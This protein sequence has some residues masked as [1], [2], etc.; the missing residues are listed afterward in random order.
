[1]KRRLVLVLALALCASPWLRS[2]G[3]G[4]PQAPASARYLGVNYTHWLIGAN[5]DLTNHGILATYKDP[6]VRA[7]V[8]GQ[9]ATMHA[10]G[11]TS[12]RFM[13]WYGLTP[14]ESWGQVQV[15]ADGKLSKTLETNLSRFFADVQH[16]GFARLSVSFGPKGSIG[17]QFTNY[18]PAQLPLDW[19]LLVQVRGL[20]KAAGI[21]DTRVDLLNEGSPNIYG[22]N[23]PNYDANLTSYL[24]EIYRRYVDAYGTADVTVSAVS[25]D[26]QALPALLTILQG[27]GRPMPVWYEVHAYM[28]WYQSLAQGIHDALAQDDAALSSAGLTTQTL[29]LGETYYGT[30]E[31][32]TGALSY[33]A[34]TTRPLSEVMTWAQTVNPPCQPMNVSPPYNV[35]ALEPLR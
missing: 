28:W 7:T 30:S 35:T 26:P 22:R 12:L 19:A 31:V 9:L 24:Q 25:E 21:P 17:P 14:A 27:S 20:L 15:G 5:C 2:Q 32:A 16:A 13:I 23:G 11:V 6:G 1:M 33:L 18:D 29:S 3:H 10:Q 8:Q 34:G 4:H